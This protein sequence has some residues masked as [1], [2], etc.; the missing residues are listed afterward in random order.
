MDKQLRCL[1]QLNW[2]NDKTTLMKKDTIMEKQYQKIKSQLE[3][4]AQLL[5]KEWSG[6]IQ[7]LESNNNQLSRGL[8]NVLFKE[9]QANEAQHAFLESNFDENIL[10]TL[11]EV[12][13]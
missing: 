5:L 12:R 8:E 3:G 2:I 13:Y 9:I 7:G 11:S 10:R 6:E 4:Y 1:E